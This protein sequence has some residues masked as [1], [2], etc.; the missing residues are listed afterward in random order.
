M[1]G[2]LKGLGVIKPKCGLV[3]CEQS[4]CMKSQ[5][6]E[7]GFEV[8]MSKTDG[9]PFLLKITLPGLECFARPVTCYQWRVS[10]SPNVVWWLVNNPFA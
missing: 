9:K 1:C 8:L 3:A 6:G 10:S 2:W 4:F 5:K 7:V